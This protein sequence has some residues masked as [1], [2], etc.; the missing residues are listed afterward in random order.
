V[1]HADDSDS[2]SGGDRSDPFRVFG[3]D[4]N[5][6]LNELRAARRSLARSAHPDHG[7]DVAAMQR[8]NVA[9]DAAVRHVT[10]RQPLPPVS[11]RRSDNTSVAQA[12]SPS[13]QRLRRPQRVQRDIPSFT[14]GALPVEAYEALLVVTSWVGEVVLDEPPYL[15]EVRLHDPLPCWCRLDL[16]PDAGASTVTLTIA[17][18]SESGETPIIEEVRDMWVAQLNS[19]GPMDG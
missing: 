17:A 3:L 4:R 12:A 13:M 1:N 19:L 14:I 11:P 5:A 18:L 16:V 15:L 10:G 9:F 2:A 8:I 7:G 6:S